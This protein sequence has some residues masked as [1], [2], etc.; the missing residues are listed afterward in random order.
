MHFFKVID[1]ALSYKKS[2]NDNRPHTIV[3]SASAIEPQYR[4]ISWHLCNKFRDPFN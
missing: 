2:I 4:L 1:I 3:V